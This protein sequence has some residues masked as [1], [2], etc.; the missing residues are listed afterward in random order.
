MNRLC[1]THYA[2]LQERLGDRV[3]L[4]DE[5]EDHAGRRMTFVPD[6]G[7]LCAD[8]DEQATHYVPAGI[9]RTA[10]E[11]AVTESATPKL[12]VEEA[13]AQFKAALDQL[14]PDDFAFASAFC[15]DADPTRALAKLHALVRWMLN[16][17]S[18]DGRGSDVGPAAADSAKDVFVFDHDDEGVAPALGEHQDG[19]PTATKPVPTTAR[20]HGRPQPEATEV[21]AIVQNPLTNAPEEAAHG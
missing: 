9:E 15:D 4:S 20:R 13:R 12:G 17:A 7:E 11:I 14:E 10:L 1:D 5:R 6:P 8:C 18:H 3:R 16:R 2:Q 19:P 21:V